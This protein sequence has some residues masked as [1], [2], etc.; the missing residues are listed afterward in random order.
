MAASVSIAT[1][2]AVISPGSAGGSSSTRAR[3]PRSRST[4]R[5]S[6]TASSTLVVVPMRR[7]GWPRSERANARSVSASP[8]RTRPSTAS[9]TP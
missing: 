2:L 9:P 5:R 1:W 8:A 7:G 4:I 6:V 3:L